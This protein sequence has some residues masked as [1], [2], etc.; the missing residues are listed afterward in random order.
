[1]STKDNI[2]STTI[3]EFINFFILSSA[4][5]T[6]QSLKDANITVEISDKNLDCFSTCNKLY[7]QVCWNK[8][9]CVDDI[10]DIF[11]DS[12][13]LHN[14]WIDYYKEVKSRQHPC[15]IFIASYLPNSILIRR[16]ALYEDGVQMHESQ[17]M[18]NVTENSFR[19][20]LPHFTATLSEKEQVLK[21]LK[22]ILQ[23]HTIVNPKLS[24]KI[25]FTHQGNLREYWNH[26]RVLC[27]FNYF[28][29]GKYFA[30][31][32]NEFL[33]EHIPNMNTHIIPPNYRRLAKP[34]AICVENC[35]KCFWKMYF[36]GC[37]YPPLKSGSKLN[38]SDLMDVNILFVGPNN[39]LPYVPGCAPIILPNTWAKWNK[40][41][42]KLSHSNKTSRMINSQYYTTSF[43]GQHAQ[44][45]LILIIGFELDSIGETFTN[46][47]NSLRFLSNNLTYIVE[48][49]GSFIQSSC[50]SLISK[51]FRNQSNIKSK[52]DDSFLLRE[53]S[54]AI[55]SIIVRSKNPEV[56]AD[57]LNILTCDNLELSQDVLHE[58]IV[59]LFE[60]HIDK[61]ESTSQSK[62]KRTNKF[63]PTQPKRQ[64]T[65][66]AF[67]DLEKFEEIDKL[68]ESDYISLQEI[69]TTEEPLINCQNSQSLNH[70]S[71]QQSPFTCLGNNC[72]LSLTSSQKS[73]SLLKS[74][75]LNISS[76]PSTQPNNEK[77]SQSSGNSGFDALADISSPISLHC[78]PEQISHDITQDRA[79]DTPQVCSNINM[80][81]GIPNSPFVTRINSQISQTDDSQDYKLL[82]NES[83]LFSSPL[84][85]LQN[86]FIS[87]SPQIDE[88]KREI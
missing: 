46:T 56:K 52:Q 23:F 22:N 2:I 68:E 65:D 43:E 19:I 25:E 39:T 30:N 74:P 71:S 14:I 9:Y 12:K 42:V 87:N 7:S 79:L 34:Q 47:V 15:F 63:T 70:I 45:S 3:S 31:D 5:L 8:A 59:N 4:H 44:N 33:N 37:I 60:I 28:Q 80:V 13:T 53:L 6:T 11:A 61:L 49:N 62:D 55:N 51:L 48:D 10:V 24:T 50:E 26:A 21:S 17:E 54:N 32:V 73:N 83:I 40:F 72:L 85:E 64:I 58:S 16:I 27:P 67:D 75:L 36:L 38:G 82:C 84:K 88:L 86:S 77:C 66:Q 18:A 81:H 35:K 57:Y 76:L 1:M 41:D 69:S 78:I 20:I 29:L